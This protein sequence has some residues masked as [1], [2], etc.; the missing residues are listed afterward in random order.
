MVYFVFLL[1][2]PLMKL[3]LS[4]DFAGFVPRAKVSMHLTKPWATY[5][6]QVYRW[7]R[8]QTIYLSMQIWPKF[9]NSFAS[10]QAWLDFACSCYGGVVVLL[11]L[12]A[13]RYSQFITTRQS[14]LFPARPKL[15]FHSSFL[16]KLNLV[17]LVFLPAA[18]WGVAR[19]LLPS[20]L[21]QW[22]LQLYLFWLMQQFLASGV[23]STFLFPRDQPYV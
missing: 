3:G 6:N 12:L 14:F 15:T 9:L 5:R 23:S 13:S 22:Q 10:K 1:D 18:V 4:I 11:V 17:K 19:I 8:P 20:E 16:W 7:Y 2:Q 21:S